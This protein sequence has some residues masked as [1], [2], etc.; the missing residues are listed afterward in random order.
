MSILLEDKS[1]NKYAELENYF[2]KV[3][4]V[5]ARYVGEVPHEYRVRFARLLFAM[6]CVAEVDEKD[7]VEDFEK[8][9][10]ELKKKYKLALVTS[11]P[12]ASVRPMLHKIKCDDLFDIVYD[13]P[14][15]RHPDKKELF[16]EFI[17]KFG[18]PEFYIGNGD[19]DIKNC[20][21]LGIKTI[22]VNWVEK[23]EFE[24]DFDIDSIE[25][26]KEIIE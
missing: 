15:E 20:K 7:V 12:E 19:K 10:R 6:S 16:K 17:E 23:S 26:L 21:E 2:D 5:M 14:M 8:Y 11:A 9:L 4:E 1:V 24:G 13:S 3:H 25:E 22:S 18:K